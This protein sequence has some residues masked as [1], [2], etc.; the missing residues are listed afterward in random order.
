MAQEGRTQQ[1]ARDTRL[2]SAILDRESVVKVAI[3]SSLIA[4]STARRHPARQESRRPQLM[5]IA[6]VLRLVA[7]QRHQPGFGLRRDGWFLARS[8]AIVEGSQRAIDQRPLDTALHC[9]M[10]DPKSLAHRAKRRV[11]PIRQQRLD[12]LL[13]EDLAHRALD[14][15]GQTSMPC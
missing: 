9:L 5:W 7:R 6:V 3:S 1:G 12:C 4:N 8:R 10:M 14:Q 2:A 15:I 11:L 13:A